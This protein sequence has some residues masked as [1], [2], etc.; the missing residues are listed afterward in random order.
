MNLHGDINLVNSLHQA[1]LDWIQLPNLTI[2]DVKSVQHLLSALTRKFGADEVIKGVP[3]IFEIQ[4][5]AVSATPASR[6]RAIAAIVVEWLAMVGEFYRIT[7]LIQYVEELKTER[8]Q[9]GE[10]S[11]IFTKESVQVETFEELET[12][13]STSVD[14]LVDRKAV[15]EIL[16]KD[17]PLRD[18]EDTE[19]TELEN[20]LL[21]DWGSD[22]YGMY[23]CL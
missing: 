23:Q 22:A 3:L 17:G 18:E 21:L 7:S 11:S 1:V 2:Q 4:K 10:Y 5:I 14:K 6:S 9:S 19:G 13:N 8:I 20:K 12:D 16:S 15:V